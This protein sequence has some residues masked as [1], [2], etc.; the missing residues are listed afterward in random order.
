MTNQTLRSESV[1]KD[2]YTVLVVDDHPLFRRGV[3]ELLTLEPSIQVVGEAGSR[4]EAIELVRRYEPD[5][6]ILDLNIKGS[7]G[8]EILTLLKE[9]TLLGALSSLR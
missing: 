4:E 5:L 2:V 7:S 9:K 1:Q 6:T 8:V 3:R